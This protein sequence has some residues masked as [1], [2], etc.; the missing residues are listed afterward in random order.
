MPKHVHQHVA[1]KPAITSFRKDA[2]QIFR[3]DELLFE[4]PSG[5]SEVK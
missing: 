2:E 1:S 3:T 5:D 4:A